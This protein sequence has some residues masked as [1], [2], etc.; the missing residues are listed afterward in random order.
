MK[1]GLFVFT[2]VVCV[3]IPLAA[4]ARPRDEVMAGAFRCAAIGDSRQW[5]DCYYGAAQPA[6]AALSLAPAPVAQTR[7]ASAPPAGT[8]T[9]TGVRDAVMSGAFRCNDISDDRRWLDCYYGAAQPMRRL[10]GLSQAPQGP[11]APPLPKAESKSSAQQ[12]GLPQP[13]NI[14]IPANIDHVVSRMASYSFDQYGIF[15]VTLAN[16]Q[17]WRQISGDTDNAHWKKPARTYVVSIS[18]GWFGSYNFQVKGDP[19]LFKVR[20]AS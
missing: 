4:E 2:A 6:R 19:G 1:S 10:L 8:P 12:F 15:T 18:R 17:V 3:A 7:L 13:G 5:L 16:G 11:V 9:D 14:G 20:R